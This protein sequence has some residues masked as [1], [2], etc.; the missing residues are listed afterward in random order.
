MLHQRHFR[1]ILHD[2]TNDIHIQKQ[3]QR[4]VLENSSTFNKTQQ[5]VLLNIVRLRIS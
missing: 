4:G 2:Y 3:P 1:A 5:V